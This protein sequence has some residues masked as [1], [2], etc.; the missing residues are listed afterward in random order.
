MRTEGI[1]ALLAAWGVC[2]TGD[3]MTDAHFLLWYHG[4][5]RVGGWREV[6]KWRMG[7][8]GG[9][10]WEAGRLRVVGRREVAGE[11]FCL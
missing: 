1:P 4:E 8:A 6:G 3:V 9:G 10:G 11:R 5:G 7:E 2:S